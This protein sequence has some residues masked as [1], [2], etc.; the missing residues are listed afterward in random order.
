MGELR[1]TTIQW[2]DPEL[3]KAWII[4][5][6][7]V[8]KRD[9]LSIVSNTAANRLAAPDIHQGVNWLKITFA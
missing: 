4:L 7:F 5:P 2:F 9:G 8:P 1:L 6:Q 3:A